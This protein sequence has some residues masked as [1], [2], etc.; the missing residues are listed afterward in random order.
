M[1]ARI[2]PIVLDVQ[3]SL[4]TGNSDALSG[5]SVVNGTDQN[6]PNWQS[7]GPLQPSLAGI[8]SDQGTTVSTSGSAT[9]IGTP[10]VRIDAS[11][12][13][14]TFSKFGDLTYTQLAAQ[15][16]ITLPGQNFS[17]SIGPVVTNG[18]CNTAVLTNW[19]DGASP[20]GPCSNYFPIIHITGDATINGVQGQGILL[21][22]GSLSVQGSFQFFGVTIVQGTL[23]TTGG[24]NTDAHFWGAT[25]VHDSVS[26]GTNQLSGHANINYSSCAL[27]RVLENTS[28]VAPAR[29]RGWVGLY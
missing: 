4:T 6:P 19:G 17:N 28:T 22:D 8:R 23:K 26:F 25:L 10:P 24:G 15:A 18:Q 1:I 29:A 16:N 2:K 12:T 7:C 20:N 3:A 14:S 11:V 9:V 5:N 21:V 27:L 13:D